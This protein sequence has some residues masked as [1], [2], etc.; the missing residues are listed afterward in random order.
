MTL[1]IRQRNELHAVTRI[2]KEPP[3]ASLMDK[4]YVYHCAASHA[5]SGAF[6]ARQINRGLIIETKERKCNPQ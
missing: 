2:G 3:K 6:K 5:D 4:D 1:T